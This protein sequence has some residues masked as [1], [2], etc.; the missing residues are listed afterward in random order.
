[1]KKLLYGDVLPLNN[2]YSSVILMFSSDNISN[3]MSAKVSAV[4][5]LPSK[6][7]LSSTMEHFV[8]SCFTKIHYQ[9]ENTTPMVY[10]YIQSPACCHESRN[11]SGVNKIDKCK[12]PLTKQNIC[13]I[14]S[15]TLVEFWQASL[16]FSLE[17]LYVHN[18][19]VRLQNIIE[20]SL[21]KESMV[22]NYFFDKCNMP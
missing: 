21:R 2:T 14:L 10:Y 8:P 5:D 12:I 18:Y 7:N 6:S 22:Y 16:V 9:T 19:F 4:S 13:R 1:M 3:G 20:L 11:E 15:V 17:N